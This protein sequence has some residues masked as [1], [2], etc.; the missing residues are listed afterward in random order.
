MEKSTYYVVINL[1]SGSGNGAK[2]WQIV[3]KTLL[4]KKKNYQLFVSEYAGHTIS[5]VN[6][7]AKDI[8]TTQQKDALILIIGGDGTLHEAVRGLGEE[9]KKTPL[10]YIP[11][12]SGNDFA[13]GVGISRKPLVALNQ[14]LK[15]KSASAF[16]I[17]EFQEKEQP[18][19]YFVNNVGVGFD[20]LVVKLTNN[21]STKATLNKYNLGSLAYVASLVKAYFK[22]RSFPIQLTVDGKTTAFKDAF[23]V[24]TTNHSYFGG[25]VNIAPMAVPT[26]GLIDVIAVSKLPLLKII[27]LFVMMLLGGRHTRFKSVHHFSGKT[28]HLETLHAVDGQADGEELGNQLFDLD[29]NPATRYFWFAN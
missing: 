28:I 8:H 1:Q 3:E 12:G 29:F 19:G 15:A 26:D 11:A 10:G 6:Q 14:I 16:D 18:D 7:L 20:A 22:Q 23:L 17:I 27:S 4:E 24:T 21:S 2:V 9:Y 13:R 5:L 25:G